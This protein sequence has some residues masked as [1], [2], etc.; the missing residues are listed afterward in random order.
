MQVEYV[1]P[2]IIQGLNDKQR[3]SSESF[4]SIIRGV[5]NEYDRS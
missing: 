3:E 2:M 5:C 1:L 4:L